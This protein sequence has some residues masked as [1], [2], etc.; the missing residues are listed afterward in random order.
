M[1]TGIAAHRE[2]KRHRDEVVFHD[3]ALLFADACGVAP[4][5]VKRP[6]LARAL[7][8][9][10][11]SP[12]Q[13]R[14]DGHGCRPDA[15]Q[16]FAAATAEFGCVTSPEFSAPELQGVEMLAANLTGETWP[17]ELL[18]ARAVTSAQRPKTEVRV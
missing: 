12:T 9:G 2:S 16:R 11:L 5:L 18:R 13:F 8:Y 6:A 4:D 10:P 15:D 3:V 14:M 7:L 1:L 17:V